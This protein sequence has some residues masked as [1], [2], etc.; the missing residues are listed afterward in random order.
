MVAGGDGEPVRA[1]LG[2]QEAIEGVAV[3][4]EQVHDGQAVA[5]LDSRREHAEVEHY[6]RNRAG[7]GTGDGRRP[8]D[9]RR[10]GGAGSI[11]IQSI[12]CKPGG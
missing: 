10:R 6:V 7:L 4:R 2:D 3:E 9:S 11:S 8:R 1:G 5:E 12:W